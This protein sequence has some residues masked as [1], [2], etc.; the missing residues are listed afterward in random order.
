MYIC[1]H[2]DIQGWKL[3]RRQN[4]VGFERSGPI[5]SLFEE[6]VATVGPDVAKEMILSG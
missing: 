4:L 3:I 5:R 1:Y 2:F 6:M